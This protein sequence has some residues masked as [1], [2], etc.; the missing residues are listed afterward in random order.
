[1][2]VT[3]Q[4]DVGADDAWGLVM[5]DALELVL[6]WDGDE[7]AAL[8][9]LV[10]DQ[11]K[12]GE[13]GIDWARVAA[14]MPSVRT[15]VEVEYRWLKLK[16]LAPGSPEKVFDCPAWVS[17]PAPDAAQKDLVWDLQILR[18][19]G[20]DGKVGSADDDLFLKFT[21]GTDLLAGDVL[22]IQLPGISAGPTFLADS[23]KDH[24]GAAWSAYS[25]MS[26]RSTAPGSLDGSM[27]PMSLH[28]PAGG[29]LPAVLLVVLGAGIEKGDSQTISMVQMLGCKQL[30]DAGL[31]LVPSGAGPPIMS[32]FRAAS[33]HAHS[34][35]HLHVQQLSLTCSLP[36]S[37]S[38]AL[39]TSLSLTEY[40][41]Y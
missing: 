28:V 23:L 12:K 13:E 29:K 15:A 9:G 17:L 20:S 6:P 31:R 4:V 5:P 8:S 11:E 10:G 19:A 34:Y 14:D 26:H 38:A 7:D 21:P 36:A 30:K 40:Q 25:K 32:C 18:D 39:P 1:M 35:L 2:T 41:T 37:T 16:T 22:A 3:P 27:R 33:A 24:T